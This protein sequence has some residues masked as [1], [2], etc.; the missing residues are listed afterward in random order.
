[1]DPA[2]DQKVET[3]VM[4]F[5]KNF[6]PVEN[7]FK[8]DESMFLEMDPAGTKANFPI[9]IEKLWQLLMSPGN[10]LMMMMN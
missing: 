10:P 8:E 9:P 4:E 6:S 3:M 7:M 1:M 5:K 2:T